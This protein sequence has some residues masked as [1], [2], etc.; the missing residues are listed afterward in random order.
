[1][2]KRLLFLN[3]WPLKFMDVLSTS[4]EKKKDTETEWKDAIGIGLAV[5]LAYALWI[6]LSSN[7]QN[8]YVDNKTSDELVGVSIIA[9][10]LIAVA[11]ITYVVQQ[12]NTGSNEFEDMLD[13]HIEMEGKERSIDGMTSAVTTF[14]TKWYECAL[15]AN[16]M[17]EHLQC[18]KKGARLSH[19]GI[20][21]LPYLMSQLLLLILQKRGTV[22]L[23]DPWP[24][25]AETLTFFPVYLFNFVFR[26]W[27]CSAMG[28]SSNDDPWDALFGP[29][30]I[31]SLGAYVASLREDTLLTSS[32][33]TIRDIAER[34]IFIGHLAIVYLTLSIGVANLVHF[35][36]LCL[37]TIGAERATHGL[38]IY[39]VLLTYYIV[40]FFHIDHDPGMLQAVLRMFEDPPSWCTWNTKL[41]VLT[42]IALAM[43]FSFWHALDCRG[44]NVISSHVNSVSR[45]GAERIKEARGFAK[46]IL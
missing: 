17:D 40:L 5:H 29:A 6:L 34:L 30:Y 20:V 18:N 36:C 25:N 27:T 46:R 7:P 45:Y 24:P 9:A 28:S 2:Q 37:K 13:E 19:R 44:L 11:I 31:L 8:L 3:G 15:L 14:F 23:M 4:N 42:C 26:L 35:C 39:V 1:M 12:G 16:R 32:A 10:S 22:N 38:L 33:V 43:A 21:L 41:E